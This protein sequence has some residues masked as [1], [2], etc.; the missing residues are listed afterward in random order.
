M[1]AVFMYAPTSACLLLNITYITYVLS[2][3]G[4]GQYSSLYFH[5]RQ[6]NINRGEPGYNVQSDGC[7]QV[8]M[9]VS[10]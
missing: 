2:H 8:N 1:L 7:D 3:Y 9:L 5:I 4:I 6:Y 10:K